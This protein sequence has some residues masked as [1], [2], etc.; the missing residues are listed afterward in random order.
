MPWRTTQISGKK[1]LFTSFGGASSESM[2][3]FYTLDDPRAGF[4]RKLV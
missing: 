3:G 1:P 4:L 2:I